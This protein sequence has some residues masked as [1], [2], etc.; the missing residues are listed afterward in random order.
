MLA[1]VGDKASNIMIPPGR[2]CVMKHAKQYSYNESQAWYRTQEESCERKRG[3]H[4]DH[5]GYSCEKN[6]LDHAAENSWHEPS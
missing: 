1:L 5:P 2:T 6:W 4:I 3:E